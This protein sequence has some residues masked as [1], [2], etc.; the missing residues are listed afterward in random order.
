VEPR[1]LLSALSVPSAFPEAGPDV[2][3]VQTHISMVFVTGERAYKVKKPVAFWG[4]LDYRTLDARR[5]CCEEEIRI[6][7][8]TAPE[9]YLGVLPIT[10]DAAGTVRVGGRGEI[11]DHCVVMR[12]FD[13]SGTLAAR[14]HAGAVAPRD[15]VD[16]AHVVVRLHACAAGD[17]AVAHEGRPDVF[18]RVIRNN[19]AGTQ[20]AVPALLPA[21]LH[22]ACAT[23]LLARLAAARPT[24]ER[25]AREGR[26]VEG[27]G[28]LRAEH[29]VHVEGLGGPKGRPGGGGG[30][31]LVDAIE[32]STAL[33][34]IDPLADLAFLAMDLAFERRRDLARVFLDAALAARSDP[35]ADELLPLHVAQRA[36]VRCAVDVRTAVDATV[37]EEAR[38]RAR[39]S[40]VR[41][42]VQA[43][44]W[45]HAGDRA[46]FVVVAGPSGVGKSTL[47]HEAGALLD[48]EVFSSDVVRKEIFAPSTPPD[49]LY[50]SDATQRTY[51][52]L[53]RRAEAIRVAGRAVVLDATYLSRAWRARAFAAAARAGARCVLAWGSAPLDVAGERI[54]AR[55]AAANDPS[56]ATIEVHRSQLTLAEPP[57]DDEG[58]PVVRFDAREDVVDVLARV[59]NALFVRPPAV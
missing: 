48:A 52:E 25:R 13:E 59:A 32:F 53:E 10:R 11:I 37:S 2:R 35:D 22:D 8:R 15:L 46:P 24:L 17:R 29:V 27:H 38:A 40:A 50:G 42:L 34:A 16:V 26:L 45:A 19:L 56:D 3:V 6:N 36:H 9:I 14:L 49:V 21:A 39:R 12:R 51:A 47:A 20:A 18:E 43:T 5:H 30:W 44:A 58:V 1:E 55:A 7:R 41:H 54:A 31:R 57:A 23:R 28:D 4:L 33:R